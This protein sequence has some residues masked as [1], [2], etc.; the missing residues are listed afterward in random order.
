VLILDEATAQIDAETEHKLM[1]VLAKAGEQ[2]RS[3]LMIVH[4]LKTLSER[5]WV[6]V[7]DQGRVVEQGRMNELL[8]RKGEFAKMWAMQSLE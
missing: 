1:K 7:M 8:E 4:R 6:V 3:I 2:S 5:D